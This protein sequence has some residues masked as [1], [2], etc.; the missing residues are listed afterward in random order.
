MKQLISPLSRSM[1]MVVDAPPLLPVTDAGL[2][3]AA[4]DGALVVVQAGKTRTEQ[5]AHAA[6]KL[7]QV[8]G[9]LLGVVLNMVKRKDI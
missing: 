8:S 9:K 5:L 7:E 4:A 6:K 1:M 2:L 3:F